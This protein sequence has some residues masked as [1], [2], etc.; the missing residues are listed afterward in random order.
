MPTTVAKR[1][2]IEGVVQGVGFRPHVH[3]L[4]RCHG[5]EGRVWNA[6]GAVSIL[7][8]GPAGA[9]DDFIQALKSDAPAAAR[10][11]R[12]T[13]ED[14]MPAGRTGFVVAASAP[15]EFERF[16]PPDLPLC[17][18]CAG[19]LRNVGRRRRHHVITCAQCG[20][21]YSVLQNL[22]YDRQ[23]TTMA[24]F[25]QCPAC[26]AEYRDPG[27]RRFHAETICCPDCGPELLFLGGT[28]EH[29]GDAALAEGV[30]LL[31]D[32][33]ILLVK[34]IG[35]YHLA[36]RPD[37]PGAVATLRALK[38][39]DDKPF[40][41]MF[42]DPEQAARYCRLDEAA[43]RLLLSPARPIVPL[44]LLPSGPAFTAETLAGDRR[45]GCFLPYSP[46]HLMLVEE[47]SPLI[48][49]S[50]NPSASP[51]IFAD[52]QALA[53]LE[54]HRERLAGVLYHRR[55]IV[56]P[57]EDSV[58]TATAEGETQVLRNSRGYAPASIALAGA[59]PPLLAMGGDLK[60]SFCLAS[61]KRLHVSQY[62][63]D[64]EDADAFENYRQGI[65]DLKRLLAIEPRLILRDSHPG[66]HSSALAEEFG[67]P[68]LE[69]QHHHAHLASVM[70][71]HGL[72]GPVLGAAFDG[73]GY[74]DDGAVWGG[75]FLLCEGEGYRRAARLEYVPLV[76]G[77]HAARDAGQGAAC[78][79]L[80][81]GLPVPAGLGPEPDTLRAA[82][83]A[84]FGAV[85]SSSMGRLFDAV[86]A[87]LGIC[88]Y[89]RYEGQC[90]VALQQRAE[91]AEDRSAAAPP[92]GFSLAEADGVI[93]IG[94][95]E[96][97]RAALACPPDLVDAFALGFHRAVADMVVAVFT[98]LGNREKIRQTALSG[99]V[100]QNALL[101]R[102]CRSG[103]LGEGFVVNINRTVPPNDG[104]ICLGQALI[105]ARRGKGRF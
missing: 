84:G 55:A 21:R 93:I 22:P 73:S 25:P 1:I 59:S 53:F 41:V 101:L 81:A 10:V 70:A 88:R 96:I 76:G 8:E 64:L 91:A 43:R 36:C 92:L 103:L 11:E 6:G 39:R 89:N 17:A 80:A 95:S 79:L 44:P 9:V 28:G 94:C 27:D 12:I 18:E 2:T 50:A 26:A 102:L 30:R 98:R 82:L 37:H 78:F 3:R 20:P 86:A 19:E 42:A 66:Y 45:C 32:G 23:N 63:G 33:E 38:G 69:V 97:L 56:R 58:A 62:F 87:I 68:I 48:M 29:R 24:E 31:E 100:F 74:G 71:E 72:D 49:T 13:V 75:E 105:G 65:L 15:G 47:V 61:G 52:D 104:G 77:D 83:N 16:I 99:G 51:I 5:V 60:A 85:P 34:G 35:G 57:V 54:R 40:A 14:A 67:L 90:A 4:A 7:A 46:L